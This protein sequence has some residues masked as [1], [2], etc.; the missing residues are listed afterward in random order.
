MKIQRLKEAISWISKQRVWTDT[1]GVRCVGHL[2]FQC[3]FWKIKNIK[4]QETQFIEI[5]HTVSKWVLDNAV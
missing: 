3:S 4:T 1:N 5:L 2:R